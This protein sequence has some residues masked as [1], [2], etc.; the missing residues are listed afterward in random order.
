M[1]LSVADLLSRRRFLGAAG[2]SAMGLGVFDALCRAASAPSPDSSRKP[3]SLI[4]LWLDGSYCQKL[5][6]RIFQAAALG[7]IPSMNLRP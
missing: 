1:P 3:C 7:L 4:L 6:M 5:W 2:T